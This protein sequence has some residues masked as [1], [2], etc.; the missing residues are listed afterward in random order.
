VQGTSYATAPKVL[1]AFVEELVQNIV[2]TCR[3]MDVELSSVLLHGSLA[4]GCFYLP[5][6]DIDLLVIVNDLS[7]P[8]GT[9]FYD[10]FKRHHDKR[11]YVGGLEASVI[12]S[13]EAQKPTH[14][15][16]LLT[17]FDEQTPEP[18][19]R[20]AGN[21]PCSETLLMNLVVARTRGLALWGLAPEAALGEVRR[22]DYLAAVQ[23][24]M[25]GF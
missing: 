12:R 21:L 25:T 11:P 17:Y 10:L 3:R 7:E 13:H 16:P 1:K 6:S 9:A 2:V 15:M 4:M 20:V 14:P 18:P 23:N 8:Q 19:Q 22:D 5:K 24:D